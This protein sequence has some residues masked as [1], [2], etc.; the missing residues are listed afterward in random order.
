MRQY[1]TE[2][3]DTFFLWQV[4]FHIVPCFFK[5][6]TNITYF[7]YMYVLQ[8][9]LTS[10]FWKKIG[11]MVKVSDFLFYGFEP[12]CQFTYMFF[13]IWHQYWLV[14]GRE[15]ESACLHISWELS[16]QSIFYKYVS[17]KLFL[18]EKK[19][20]F[21]PMCYCLPELISWLRKNGIAS[22]C[23]HHLCYTNIV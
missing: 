23:I 1:K 11:P 10:L 16:T 20:L 2:T 6:F 12:Y 19:S 8:Q 17:T 7:K 21:H 3:K 9:Y 22:P 13:L 4:F 5:I 14:P 15:L 18:I